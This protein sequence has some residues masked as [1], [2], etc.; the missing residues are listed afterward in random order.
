MCGSD[1]V[2]YNKCGACSSCMQ[3][4]ID[5]CC[6]YDNTQDL[7]CCYDSTQYLGSDIKLVDSALP[8]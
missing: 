3:E 8:I 6:C 4:V 1:G 5:V 7:G 2:V